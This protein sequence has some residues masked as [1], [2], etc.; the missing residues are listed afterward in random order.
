MYF[1][2]EDTLYYVYP[3]YK[4]VSF[5]LIAREHIKYLR[6]HVKIHEIDEEVLDNIMWIRNRRI[7]LHP[8]LYTL[9]GDKP[10]QHALKSRRLYKLTKCK[11]KLGGFETCDTDK[12]SEVAVNILNKMDL[13]FV[14]STFAKETFINCGVNTPIEILPHG[15]ND[16]FLNENKEIT[17]CEI[18]NL[19]KI[20]KR[21]NAIFVLFFLLHSGFRKGADLV[22]EAMD[23][24][25]NTFPYIYLI[26]KTSNI[27]DTYINNLRKLKTIEV[28]GWFNEDELRQL[29]D[30]CDICLVPSRGGGFELN[31][32]E[33]ISRGLPTI[34]PNAACFKDYANYAITYEAKD[35]VQLFQ[36]NPIHIGDGFQGDPT[37]IAS[38]IIY[39]ASKLEDFKKE[40][41]KYAKEVREKYSWKNICETL[42]NKLNEYDFVLQ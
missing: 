20:K 11:Y 16:A 18:K 41:A 23:R 34:V 42:W 40:F 19:E 25:Q 30:V 15:L 10:E 33:A 22:Y 6:Q 13:I 5:S 24:V 35:K 2:G 3:I 32:L 27:N 1:E 26:V 36:D 9:I 38:K 31:A 4:T 37:E 28:S 29:Y 14:P 12:I 21:D 39:V 7:L 8:I 17:N